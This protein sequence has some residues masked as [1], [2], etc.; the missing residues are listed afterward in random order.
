MTLKNLNIDNTWTLF[1]DRDGVINKKIEGDYVRDV[2]NL[3][4]LEG[5]KKS[6]V[7]FSKLFYKIIVVTNQ[8]GVGKKNMTISDLERIHRS[9][10]EEIP[11]IDKIYCCTHLISDKCLCRKPNIGMG[12]LAQQ[13]FKNIN[14]QKSVMIGDSESDI[15]FGKKLKM[16]TVIIGNE[17]ELA[18][19]KVTS[20]SEID[21][22]E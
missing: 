8:Q 10:L 16:K 13:D 12:L 4:I 17:S 19:Y 22:Y 3:I 6:I 18:D 14:F 1:L 11:Q 5:V 21:L 20:L 15:I 2:N 9:L 7:E